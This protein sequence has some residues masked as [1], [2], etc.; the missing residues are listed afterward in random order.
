[1]NKKILLV[2]PE[3]PKPSKSKNHQNFMPIGLLKLAAYH[4]KKRDAICLVEGNHK[5]NE[6]AF[7]DPDGTIFDS[8]EPNEILITSY[9]T[10]WSKYV[11]ESVS[12]YKKLYPK[13][14][15]I[16]GGIYP[17]LMPEHCKRYT[18]CD[19]VYIGVH[20]EAEKCTPAFDYLEEN[21]GEKNYQI[22]HTTRGCIRRCK[23]C[24][25]YRIEPKFT[26]KKSIKKEIKRKR[27]IFYDNN[28]LANPHIED[29]LTEL[30]YLKFKDKIKWCEAQS[31]IDGRILENI[32]DIAFLLKKAGFKDIRF[33]WDGPFKNAYHIKKQLDILKDAGF[34][35][36]ENVFVF[37][38]Y[39]WDIPFEEMERKR[40][41]CWEW[42]VQI[43]D[44]RFR[45]LDQTFDEY[46]GQKFRKGQTSKDYYIHQK[47][48][49][50]D[51]KI[52]KFRK[53]IRRQNI[54]VRLNIQFYTNE[55][56]RKRLNKYV[57]EELVNMA[58]TY[59]KDELIPILNSLK[60]PY[61]F[62]E[63]YDG[64]NL[65]KKIN[66]IYNEFEKQ[67]NE[68]PLNRFGG[69]SSKFIRWRNK[70]HRRVF[71]ELGFLQ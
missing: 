71:N 43:S 13:A 44:C 68:E 53:E 67:T 22:I 65:H 24:G 42:K 32:P 49:W 20:E 45:P 19:E 33:S 66:V 54:C 12:H 69:Y 23:F 17:S 1:M 9:F 21:F 52:R 15:I 50:T 39:N 3:F 10:Y 18:K 38:I 46:S 14:K 70:I 7:E 34:N 55:I 31:G 16:V 27:I 64:N 59:S 57:V 30:A 29:I 6:I 37:M 47:A 35:I 63:D 4:R 28:L 36:R 41:K 11:K 40:I 25:V 2:E 8:C 56:E 51:K 60:I 26:Y 48:G 58:R 62:P 5:K 61:W